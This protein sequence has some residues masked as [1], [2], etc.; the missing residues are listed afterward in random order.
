MA[1]KLPH[2][3][4]HP[5]N[6]DI[7]GTLERYLNHGIMPGSFMTAVIENNLKEALGRADAYNTLH[8]GNIVG[9]VYN[10]VPANAWG[11]AEKVADYIRNIKK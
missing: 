8:L 5:V 4:Y 1:I 2:D 11:S 10:H 7:I 9:Y 6:E 3:E